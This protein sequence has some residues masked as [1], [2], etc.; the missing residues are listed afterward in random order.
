[1]VPGCKENGGGEGIL[2][3]GAAWLTG[4]IEVVEHGLRVSVKAGKVEGSQASGALRV[5]VRDVI[6]TLETEGVVEGIQEAFNS[7]LFS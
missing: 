5:H 6:V 7:C 3:K 4:R 1:M 2:G